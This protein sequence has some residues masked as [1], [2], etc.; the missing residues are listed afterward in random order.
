MNFKTLEAARNFLRVYCAESGS[1]DEVR[2]EIQQMIQLNPRNVLT[3]LNALESL[4]TD[5]TV[6]LG[7]FSRLVAIDANWPLDDPSDVGA[8]KW[9]REL[10]TTTRDTLGNQQTPPFES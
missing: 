5:P 1:L 7:T 4:L 9:L 8:M 2:S 10:V 6:E 3:G